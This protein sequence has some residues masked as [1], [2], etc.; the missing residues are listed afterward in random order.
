MGHLAQTMFD[1]FRAEIQGTIPDWTLRWAF[2]TPLNDFWFEESTTNNIGPN[3]L[4]L[5]GVNVS[6]VGVLATWDRLDET[7]HNDADTD[8]LVLFR[9]VEG[10][11]IDDN[12]FM[13]ARASGL[14]GAEHGYTLRDAQLFDLW[15]IA[16]WQVG[17]ENILG[18]WD[19][20]PLTL[21]TWY[22]VQF[23]V[24]GEP[25]VTLKARLW[26]YGTMNP[27][28]WDLEVTDSV[29]VLPGWTGFGTGWNDDIEVDWVSVGTDGEPAQM[30]NF[31]PQAGL[32]VITAT[33]TRI[34]LDGTSHLVFVGEP[35]KALTWAITAGDGSLD[36]ASNQTDELGRA[37]NTYFPGT[38][39]DKTIEVTYGT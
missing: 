19:P 3:I 12:F 15:E 34:H 32:N 14:V 28:K 20:G 4:H 33:P 7:V 18:S 11:S 17:V 24:T 5:E 26:E 30:P 22:W 2:A 31:L 10:P 27:H 9:Y 36:V 25:T 1:P 37:F 29:H 8:M 39:G 13:A 21:N 23:R 35:N 16:D 38:V 6:G